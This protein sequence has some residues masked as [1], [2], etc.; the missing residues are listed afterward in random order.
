[1][2]DSEKELIPYINKNEF[3]TFMVGFYNFRL[4]ELEI[5]GLQEVI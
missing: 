4:R 1:M 2:K 5:Q 3:P